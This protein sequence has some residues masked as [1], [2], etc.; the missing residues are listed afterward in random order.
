VTDSVSQS[1]NWACTFSDRQCLT[2]QHTTANLLVRA[3]D[4]PS[5]QFLPPTMNATQPALAALMAGATDVGASEVTIT[6]AGGVG[7]QVRDSVGAVVHAPCERH[8]WGRP[9]PPG[10]GGGGAR[11]GARAR[12]RPP[13]APPPP[14]P[15]TTRERHHHPPRRARQCLR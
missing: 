14:H 7:M 10:G 5:D 2:E 1:S 6:T 12:G 8:P 11:G 9:P 3:F 4:R 13:P 15:P